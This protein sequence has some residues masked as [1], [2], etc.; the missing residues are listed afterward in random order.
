MKKL[1]IALFALTALGINATQAA[2]ETF[3]YQLAYNQIVDAP[4]AKPGITNAIVRT[5]AT[6]RWYIYA[7]NATDTP[8]NYML[9][10][11]AVVW[12]I[13][14]TSVIAASVREQNY[15]N[16]LPFTSEYVALFDGGEVIDYTATFPLVYDPGEL[17][18]FQTP[19]TLQVV[20][21]LN[22]TSVGC[23]Y[24]GEAPVPG[25][26][27]TVTITYQYPNVDDDDCHEHHGKKHHRR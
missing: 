23:T 27:V 6:A 7:N 14:G 5:V 24:Y 17:A 19:H 26:A 16:L 3:V 21:L 2:D 4:V 22:V 15:G 1:L 10:T 9:D 11:S 18:N 20:P 25:N 13:K 12:T 8:S